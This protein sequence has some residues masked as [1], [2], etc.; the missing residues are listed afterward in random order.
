MRNPS[1]LPTKRYAKAAFAIRLGEGD[2]VC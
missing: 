1:N 2:E